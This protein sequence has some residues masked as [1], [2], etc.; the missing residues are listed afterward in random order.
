MVL[1]M[2]IVIDYNLYMVLFV[3]IV[4]NYNGFSCGYCD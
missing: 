3:V 2:D 1:I 4:I